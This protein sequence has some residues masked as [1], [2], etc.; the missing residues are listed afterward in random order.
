[1][2]LGI[3]PGAGGIQRLA[4]VAGIGI[5]KEM[6]LTTRRLNAEEAYAKGLATKV[7]PYAELWEET[8]KLA[9]KIAGQAPMAVSFAKQAANIALDTDKTTAYLLEKWGQGVLSTTQDAAEGRQAFAEKRKPAYQG[10]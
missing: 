8:L 5:A 7:V 3:I 4:R 6:A 10:K 9:R 1:V 2:G